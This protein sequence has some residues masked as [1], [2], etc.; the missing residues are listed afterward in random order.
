MTFYV[1][2][3]SFLD[4]P[5]VK[6]GNEQLEITIVP[7]WGSN[8][9]SIER[10]QPKVHILRTPSSI[11]EY[12]Q[13]PVQF[14]TPILFP[15]NRIRDGQFTFSNR[16]Y[17]FELTEPDKHNHIHGFVYTKPWRLEHMEANDERAQII[18]TIHSTD[19]PDI[20]K[21]FP[22]SFE[23]KMIYTLEGSSL[24]QEAI[25]TNDGEEMFPW[26]IG[27]HTTFCFPEQTS[28]FSLQASKQWELNDRLLPTG[29]LMEVPNTSLTEGMNLGGVEL[30]DAF[31]ANQKE[32][33]EAVMKLEEEGLNI[34]YKAD[35]HFKHW[36]VYNADGRKGYVCPE[37]YTWITDAPN[38]PLP[39]EL[40]GVQ[41]LEPGTSISTTTE[42]TITKTN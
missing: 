32:A 25:I 7:N 26:G 17:T 23:I 5:A 16:T 33:N 4:Q 15:P 40:T 27:Y 24:K 37:P 22:H 28:T 12:E 31:L 30:D 42:I 1:K 38:L 21:Q 13:A 9:I 35:H 8:L 14:G 41:T 6:A 18:T 36:V 10:L 39:K 11:E 34:T 3:D 29:E 2:E 20:L 19:H